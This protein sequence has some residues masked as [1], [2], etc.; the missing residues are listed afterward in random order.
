MGETA[1]LK[2]H[3]VDRSMELWARAQ[4]LIPGG[5]QLISRRPSRYACGVSPVYAARAKGARMWDVDGNEYIDWVSGIGAIIL[6][7]ADP[8]VD[9]AVREQISRGTMYSI[10]HEL[11]IELAE[12]L[13]RTIPCAEMVRYAKCGGES[14]AIAVR[15]ARGATGRDKVLF[16]GYHGWHDWYLAANLQADANLNSHLFPGIEP[17]GVPKALASTA[18]PFPYGDLAALGTLLDEHRNEVAAV[19]MEPLRSQEPPAGYLA[20]VAK[21][22]REH[23]AVL[24][25]DEVST[26]FRL[27]YDG[28][29]TYVGVT[30]DMAVFAKSISNGY[31]MGAVVGKRD[32]MQHAIPMFIS[33]TYWSDTLGL[34]A[35]LTT[36]REIRRREIPRHI[37][38]LGTALKERLNQAARA[39][40]MGVEC[41][42][43]SVHPG[44]KFD[45]AD[46]TTQA[47]LATIYIQE[48]AKRGCHG[49]TSFYTNGAQGEAELEQTSQAAQEVFAILKQG[50]E[51]GTLDSLLECDPRQEAFRRLVS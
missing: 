46:A 23:G 2:S 3:R 50:Q 11:E 32:V 33:S 5:T 26:G 13:V 22:A 8:V 27:G 14:C 47:R 44:L 24:I 41:V 40:G 15:I 1:T 9:E 25:F 31:A 6:G 4:Q 38:R 29:Q 39:T 16:C 7:Y 45:A 19:I 35:A 43:L 48:M 20:A 34:R 10:N 42:G 37:D 49:Y 30:P 21:L 18:F 36:L 17:I 28:V 51:T 12:E